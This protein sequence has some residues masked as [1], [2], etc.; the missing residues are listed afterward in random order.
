M[1]LNFNNLLQI[2]VVVPMDHILQFIHTYLKLKF[3]VDSL[4]L[5]SQQLVYKNE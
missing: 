3:P 2:M 4:D 5:F 1:I